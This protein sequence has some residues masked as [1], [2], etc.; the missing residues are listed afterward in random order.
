MRLLA[1]LLLRPPLLALAWLLVWLRGRRLGRTGVLV[2]RLGRRDRESL[3]LGRLADLEAVAV[4]ERVRAIVVYI[5]GLSGGWAGLQEWR[6]ALERLKDQGK[7]VAVWVEQPGTAAY[8]LACIGDH[9]V[10]PPLGELALVGV[11]GRLSFFGGALERHGVR[12]ELEAAG[13]YKSYGETFTRTHPTPENREAVRALV[14]DL[15]D[16]VLEGI[17]RHRGL[18]R[19]HLQ[20]L[21]EQ[22]P[23]TADEAL[24]AGLIDQIGFEEVLD[25]WLTE[26]LDGEPRR[27]SARSATRVQGWVRTLES[28]L[29]GEPVIAVVHL[30]G[31]VVMDDRATR[32]RQAISA[33]RTVP[34][35]KALRERD[36]VRAVVLAVDSP[37]GS[38]LASDLIWREVELLNRAKPVV[39]CFGD[40]AASGGYYLAAA[41]SEIVARPGTLTGSIGVVGGK[42]VVGP[43]LGR[44]GVHAE[45]VAAGPN[46]SIHASDRPF[47]PEQ[48]QRFRAVL[49]RT[50][51]LFI[52]R[53]AAGRRRPEEAV[54]PY[55][56]GR[57][58]TGRAAVEHGLVD[59]LGG[60]ADALVRARRLAGLSPAQP[61]RRTDLEHKPRTSMLGRLVPE[62]A[63][64]RALGSW[65]LAIPGLSPE[66]Q[67]LADH[68]GQPLALAPVGVEF[69]HSPSESP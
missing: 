56:R 64:L 19:E 44:H 66:A 13:E 40:T 69:S 12:F 6:A 33:R 23:L 25:E 34:D 2:L 57:V 46:A 30:K 43:A 9:V 3:P 14:E 58:W 67:L 20:A 5:D 68:P 7:H 49:R 18:E 29:S 10:M 50:Y 1:R 51:E 45:W 52:Q 24:E 60:L 41:A 48:R 53:V 4:S 35:L 16:G 28:A 15:H 42:M 21:V 63:R 55:A 31:P 37:G 22:A 39:A 11:A 26:K 61:W 27:L 8:S 62:L 47:S 65:G 54:E 38:A 59:H 17:H 36:R 32:G